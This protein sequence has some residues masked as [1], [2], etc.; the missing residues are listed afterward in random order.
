MGKQK[1]AE[2]TSR[3]KQLSG[4][5][6]QKIKWL[7]SIDQRKSSKSNIGKFGEEVLERC[8]ENCLKYGVCYFK[9]SHRH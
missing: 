4:F 1:K 8:R 6:K 7:S 5:V 3:T 2:L 9:I